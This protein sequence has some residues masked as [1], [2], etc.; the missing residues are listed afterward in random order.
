MKTCENVLLCIIKNLKT[1]TADLEQRTVDFEESA[2]INAN[3]IAYSVSLLLQE[4]QRGNEN[5]KKE[6]C[7][8]NMYD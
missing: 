4:K 7:Q 8:V 6:Y 2:N 3:I 1:P 5:N